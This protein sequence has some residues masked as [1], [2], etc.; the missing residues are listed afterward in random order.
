MQVE[1]TVLM[2]KDVKYFAIEI[3]TTVSADALSTT[4]ENSKLI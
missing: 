3:A 2:L 1:Y 4:K